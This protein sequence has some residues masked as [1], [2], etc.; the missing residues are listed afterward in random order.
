MKR[1][2]LLS[3]SGSG[4]SL[5]KSHSPP[6]SF[7]PSSGIIYE[8]AFYAHVFFYPT[9]SIHS[10]PPLTFEPPHNLTTSLEPP[11][12]K[13]ETPVLFFTPKY[14][15]MAQRASPNN[16]DAGWLAGRKQFHESN[17]ILSGEREKRPYLLYNFR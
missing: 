8:Y 12:T 14:F 3:Q 4:P 1:V 15:G 17:K 9:T 10:L 7:D 2:D 13:D 6:C 11:L 16:R 5:S